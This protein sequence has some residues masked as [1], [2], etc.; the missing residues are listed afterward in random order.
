VDAFVTRIY[1]SESGDES[2]VYSTYLGGSDD[3]FGR[4][5]AV[6]DGSAIVTG[7]TRSTDYPLFKCLSGCALG[8]K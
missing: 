8:A 7:F 4:G 3:D 6:Y 1:A 2:L 5:I